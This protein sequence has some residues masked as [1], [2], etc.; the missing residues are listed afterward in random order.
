MKAKQAKKKL[1]KKVV[2]QK[3]TEQETFLNDERVAKM[4]EILTRIQGYSNEKLKEILRKNG[5]S[6]SGTKVD[7]LSKV[8]DGELFGRV[9]KC[10]TCR[11]GRPKMDLQ[12]GVYHC[13]GYYEDEAFYQCTAS[14]QFNK[15][16]RDKW[17]GE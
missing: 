9:P 12:T 17:L 7:L 15:L 1:T 2:E 5:Q 3:K 14:F 13:T 16:E 11:G 6:M 4:K 10:P 8:L